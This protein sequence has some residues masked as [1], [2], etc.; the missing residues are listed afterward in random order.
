[1]PTLGNNDFIKHD[2]TTLQVNAEMVYSKY[3]DIL[4]TNNIAKPI[5]KRTF[6]KGGYY[7]YDFEKRKVS[8]LAINTV[9]YMT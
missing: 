1:M 8:V 7:R 6:L 5:D 2:Q 9:D 3:Y 4:F